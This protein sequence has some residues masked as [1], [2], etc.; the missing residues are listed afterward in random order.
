MLPVENRICANQENLH[1]RGKS[2]KVGTQKRYIRQNRR[3]SNL[4]GP[5]VLENDSNAIYKRVQ[6][7]AIHPRD[8]MLK[9]VFQNIVKYRYIYFKGSLKVYNV[10]KHY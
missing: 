1:E 8:W 6:T 4:E 10:M 3:E 7:L 9:R 2:S 5:Q